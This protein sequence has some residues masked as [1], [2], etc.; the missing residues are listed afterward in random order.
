MQRFIKFVLVYRE[1]MKLLITGN[2][3]NF[4]SKNLLKTQHKK[5]SLQIFSMQLKQLERVPNLLFEPILLVWIRNFLHNSLL[6]SDLI[7]SKKQEQ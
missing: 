1:V 4:F 6:T 2:F 5:Q 3:L 7:F